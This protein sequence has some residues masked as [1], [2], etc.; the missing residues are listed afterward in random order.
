[1]SMKT[2]RENARTTVRRED[3]KQGMEGGQ[4]IVPSVGID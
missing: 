4:W 3:S 1:M 2:L